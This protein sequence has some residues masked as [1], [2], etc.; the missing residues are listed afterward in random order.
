MKKVSLFVLTTLSVVSCSM[1]RAADLPAQEYKAPAVVVPQA[2]YN[3]TG[4]YV[5]V[6][7]GYSSGSQDPLV[8]FGNRFD[9]SS[10]NVSGGSFGG[11]VGA[12]IQQGYVVLGLESDLSWADIKGNSIV[13]PTVLG[14]GIGPGI[15]LNTTTNVSAFGTARVRVGAALN[16]WLIYT[17]GGLAVM[18]TSANGTSI[19]GAACGTLGVFPNCSA[20]SWNPGLAAGLGAEWGF[21]QKWSMKLEYL[22]TAA[23]GSGVSV[24][25]LNTF[26][27]GINYRF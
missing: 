27:G 9:R 18:K 23:I 3:W 4:M 24:Q 2:V 17:T 26:R 21:S 14:L 22:Y 16:N 25:T 20:S 6:T 10:I 15:T 1:A 7:G 8:L 19:A 5:G 11:T 12:Q 13:T